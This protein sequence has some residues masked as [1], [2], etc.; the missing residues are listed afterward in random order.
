MWETKLVFINFG[1][2]WDIDQGLTIV[3]LEY[4]WWMFFNSSLLANA[5]GNLQI[6]EVLH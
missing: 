4:T 1:L 2:L 5:H 6:V 3:T